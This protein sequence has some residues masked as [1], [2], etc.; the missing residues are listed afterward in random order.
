MASADS[1]ESGES[2]DYS[3][4]SSTVATELS[5]KVDQGSFNVI[6]IPQHGKHYTKLLHAVARGITDNWSHG[7]Q[8]TLFPN[9]DALHG[10]RF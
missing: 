7:R 6:W 2:D 10:S 8:E 5:P 3:N 1:G 4:G 9:T